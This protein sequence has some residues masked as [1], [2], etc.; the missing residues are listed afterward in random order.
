MESYSDI[1]LYYIDY[2]D[3]EFYGGFKAKNII[4]MGNRRF[5]VCGFDYLRTQ[6]YVCKEIF[7]DNREAKK[8]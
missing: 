4:Y 2:D 7:K 6:K 1:N 5:K 3:I 8:R